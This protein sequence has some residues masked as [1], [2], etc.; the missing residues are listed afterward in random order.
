VPD[1]RSY[2]LHAPADAGT[3][4]FRRMSAVE[5]LSEIGEF[6]IECLSKE[7]FVDADKLLGKKMGVTMVYSG[8][9]ER[10]FNGYVTRFSL[11][12]TDGDYR[13]YRASVRPWLWFLGLTADCRIF[14]NQSAVDIIKQVFSEQERSNFK[15]SLSQTYTAREYC[16]QYRETDLDFV[17]RLME[18]EGIYYFFEHD[19]GHDTLVLAD[20][21]SAHSD[22]KGE[23]EIPFRAPVGSLRPDYEHVSEW[24]C[25]RQV[26]SGKIVLTDYDFTRP[27]L[28]LLAEKQAATENDASHERFDYPGA[29]V[30][31]PVGDQFANARLNALQSGGETIHAEANARNLAAGALFE[32]AKHPDDAQNRKYLITRVRHEMVLEGYTSSEEAGATYACD[33]GAMPSAQ[34]FRPL[35]RTPKPIVR[36]PQTAMVTGASGDEICTDKYGRIKVQF[37]WDRLGKNDDKS[38]C[39]IRVAFPWAGKGWGFVTLPRVGQEVVVEF[40]EGDPDRPLITGSVYNADQMPPYALPAN[41]TQSGIKSRSSLGGDTS[42]FN[43]IRFEDKKGSELV[44]VQAE[45]DRTILV[46]N[47]EAHTV[48]HDRTKTIDHDETVHVKHDR[49]ERVDNNETI[50]IGVDQTEMIGN[51][52]IVTVGTNHTETIGAAM[53]VTVGGSLTEMVGTNYAETVGAAM[54]LTVGAALAITVGAVMAETVGG[55]KTETVGGVKAESI[56][57]SSTTNVGGDV[58][59]NFGGKHSLQV[60]KDQSTTIAGKQ[61]VEVTKEAMLQAKKVQIVADDEISIKT[62]DAEITMKKNGDITIKGGKITIKGNS[63]VVIKGSKIANN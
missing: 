39:W 9:D 38:S 3:L 34:E 51:N 63:D 11:I 60:A 4:L 23:T 8:E 62:G 12:G 55:A 50:S 35:C 53:S 52:R 61:T 56:G 26:E 16:V 25:E 28:S 59:E 22:V 49:N 27:R 18:Q 33:F 1:P 57:G 5:A 10:E 13:V 30:D 19:G 48:N 40:L 37:H 7:K 24:C 44:Y 41:K 45:K 6:E 42:N 2:T 58:T 15:L 21:P 32:L 17:C 14:Q 46:K 43:E 20:A 31:K 36:G 29:Y 54:E 47:D